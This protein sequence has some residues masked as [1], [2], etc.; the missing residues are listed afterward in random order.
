MGVSGIA[1]ELT[2]EQ[3]AHNDGYDKTDVNGQIPCDNCCV[4]NCTGNLLHLYTFSSFLNMLLHMW[5]LESHCC[6]HHVV[7]AIR[8]SML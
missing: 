3:Q 5:S 6:H 7:V 2:L 8:L 1:K 4:T